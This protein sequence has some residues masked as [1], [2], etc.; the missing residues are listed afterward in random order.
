MVRE[1][2]QFGCQTIVD[3]TS[4][5]DEVL[6]LLQSLTLLRHLKGVVDLQRDHRSKVWNVEGGMWKVRGGQRVA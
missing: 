4:A 1:V 6:D 2:F 3:G 5:Y